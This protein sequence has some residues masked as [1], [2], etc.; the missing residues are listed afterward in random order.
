MRPGVN[1]ASGGNISEGGGHSNPPGQEEHTSPSAPIGPDTTNQDT[2]KMGAVI[3]TATNPSNPPA[4]KQRSRKRRNPSSL[5]STNNPSNNPQTVLAAANRAGLFGGTPANREPDAQPESRYKELFRGTRL[6][7]KLFDPHPEWRFHPWAPMSALTLAG[8][9][10]NTLAD[11]GGTN[12]LLQVE[13]VEWA[14][15][16]GPQPKSKRAI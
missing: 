7:H 8:E 14:L 3:N 12:N 4:P 9:G 11:R 15:G 5:A 6:I 10:W 2:N 1:P 13:L 16:R